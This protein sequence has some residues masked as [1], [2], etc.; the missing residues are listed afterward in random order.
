MRGFYLASTFVF[1]SFLFVSQVF[2]QALNQVQFLAGSQVEL[3]GTSTATFEISTK[4]SDGGAIHIY[5]RETGTGIYV[6]SSTNYVGIGIASPSEKLSVYGGNIYLSNSGDNAVEF[7][8]Q[9]GGVAQPWRFIFPSSVNGAS[10]GAAAN[11]FGIYNATAGAYLAVFRTDKSVVLG[12]NAINIDTSSKVGIGT[13]SPASVLHVYSSAAGPVATFTAGSGNAATFNQPIT[14]GYPSV[15]TDAMR[16]DYADAYYAPMSGA[17]GVWKLSGNNLYASST[18]WNVGIGTTTPGAKLQVNDSFLVSYGSNGSIVASTTPSYFGEAGSPYL[19]IAG[20]V[21]GTAKDAVLW[22]R[23]AS[24]TT[25]WGLYLDQNDSDKFKIQRDSGTPAITINFSNYVGI[26]TTTPLGALDVVSTNTTEGYW[27]DGRAAMTGDAAGNWLRLNT[28]NTWTNGIYTPGIF[29]ADSEI[30]QGSADAGSYGIQTTGALYVS[31]TAILAAKTGNVGIGTTTPATALHVVAASGNAATF[32]SAITVGY[33]SAATDAM[34]KDYADEY[35]APMS[36]A[37]GIWK[38]S[39]NNLYAS[40]TLYSVGIGTTTP[41]TTLHIDVGASTNRGFRIGR[42]AAANNPYVDFLLNT[43]STPYFSIQPGDNSTF[44]NTMINPNGG[45]VGIGTTTTPTAKLD[46]G[47][48][49]NIAGNLSFGFVD[50]RTIHLYGDDASRYANIRGKVQGAGD[51]GISFYTTTG[52]EN[53]DG[54]RMTIN[55]DGNVG[56]GTTTPATKLQVFGDIRVGNSGTNGCI[57]G[58]GGATLV[59]TCTSDSR[60]K[61]NIVSFS[62]SLN[63]LVSLQPVTY[64]WRIEEFPDKHFGSGTNWGLV[65][66]D[67]EKILPELVNTDKDGYKAVKYGVELQMLTIQ[68]IKELNAENALLKKRIEK[69]ESIINK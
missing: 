19:L 36:G 40:S 50:N 39:G 65:A 67:V 55:H 48:N 54:E 2:G 41:T 26:G 35:Y 58:F 59:G 33:P 32:S 56:I 42:G 6:A 20:G 60:F 68:S 61:K 63:K 52:S 18:S 43:V 45:Y 46:V 25:N 14:I 15:S 34:R 29:R 21:S 7:R 30:R 64:E 66:Q 8:A 62:N 49:V 38:L 37:S 10:L 47:G 4:S 31:S 1:A 3:V 9:A 22:L 17:S 57:Q 23:N 11:N 27:L 24:T 13:S 28:S 12:S 51:V 5:T 44:R 69:L 53:N 16:K